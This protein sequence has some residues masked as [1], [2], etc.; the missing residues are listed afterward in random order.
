MKFS[1]N[2]SIREINQIEPLLRSD[3]NFTFQ[4]YGKRLYYVVEDPLNNSFYRVGVRE[5]KFMSLLDGKTSIE[6]AM[7]LMA[8]NMESEALDSREVLQLVRWLLD[9]QLV[10]TKT[11]VYSQKLEKIAH[12]H[13][14]NLGQR[15]QGL[16]FMK[17]PLFNPDRLLTHIGPF[18]N[19][20]WK[21]PFMLL[22][23]LFLLIA[24]YLVSCYWGRF[25]ES[26]QGLLQISNWLW[27]YLAVVFLK[28]IHEMAH[29]LVCKHYGGAV[30]EMGAMLIFFF[31]PGLCGYKFLMEIFFQMAENSCCPRWCVFPS[32]LLLRWPSLSGRIPL[33]DWYVI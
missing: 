4:R 6:E 12:K 21:I 28:L 9:T 3:L 5:Y 22:W 31:P 20:L 19:F 15:I 26:A 29:G 1:E 2:H 33:L 13:D 10:Q 14:K 25:V 7:G 23:L 32:F 11:S 17:I 27:I 8:A 16:L 18:L 24:V 30:P